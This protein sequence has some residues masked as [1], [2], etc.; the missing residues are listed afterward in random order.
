MLGHVGG[1]PV[2]DNKQDG[3]VHVTRS[4]QYVLG[5]YPEENKLM[6]LW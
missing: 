6:S 3:L 2:K 4:S 1:K 5:P